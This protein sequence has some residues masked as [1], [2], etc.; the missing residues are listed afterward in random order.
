[1]PLT[2]PLH[3]LPYPT[4]DDTVDVPRDVKALADKLDPMVGANVAGGASALPVLDVGIA[5]QIRAGR[6]LAAADFTALGLTQPTGLWNLSDLTNL[7]SDGRPLVNKGAVPFGV[8]INGIAATAAVFAGST[9]QALYI[10]DTG[11]ADPLRIR[12]GSIGCWLRTAKRGAQQYAVSKMSTGAG[13]YGWAVQIASTNSAL[14]EMST[15]GSNSAFAVG[16]SDVADDRWHHVVGTHDGTQLRL[17]IDGVLE[18]VA[19]V[20]GLLFASSAPL[21]IGGRAADAGTASVSPSYGR[22]DE[23]FVSAD[24]LTEDQ[25]RGLYCASIPHALGVTPGAVRLNVHRRRRGAPLAVADFTTQPLRLHNFTAGVLTDQGSNAQALTNNG[26]AVSV[27]GAD[28]APGGAYSFAG[29]Q[30]LSATDAGLPGG[31]AARSYGAWV[32]TT[33]PAGGNG[34]MGYGAA[35][36]ANDMRF[37]VSAGLLLVTSGADA[38][39]GPFAADGQWHLAI[40]VD[41]NAAGDGVRRKLFMDG[42]LVGGSTVLNSITLTGAN[43]FRIGAWAD[44]TGL[45]TG[46]IDG[47]FVTGYALAQDE[48]LRLYAKASQDLGASP[49]EPG[50]HVERLDSSAL[51]WVADTLE[52]Q[53]TVDVG[54]VA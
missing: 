4:P 11:A 39:T 32:K 53:H 8:G 54:V 25:V 49:K 17:Y 23:A 3:A 27:A 5:G 46:Q 42:R 21:N 43:R 40:A 2:T 26:A 22:V 15:D 18:G 6:Q 45:F 34:F 20:P 12:T 10:A 52:S 38:I 1:M 29:A 9:G 13:Q 44:G 37:A 47:A 24:V 30:S 7:G 51:L 16:V 41:D 31:L 36:G 28:G 50:A 33:N 48:I 19:A 14:V 35:P